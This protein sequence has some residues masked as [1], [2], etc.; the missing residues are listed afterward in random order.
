MTNS[1]TLSAPATTHR[2]LGTLT[3]VVS[4]V[5]GP[6]LIAL[7]L[8]TLHEPWLG[9]LPN[10]DVVDHEHG[11]L[12]LSFNL[13]AAAFPFLFG[14]VFA[15]ARAARRAPRLAGAGLA[16]SVLGLSAMFANAMLSVPIVL[17][18]GIAEHAPLDELAGRL[19]QP[20]LV[21]L[22]L[23]PLFLVGSI[24]QAVALRR[25][26]VLSRWAALAIGV[27]GLFPAAMVLGIGVL[28]LPIAALRIAGSVPIITVT[29]GTRMDS[30]DA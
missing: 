26:G 4:L 29:L 25:A 12:M 1:T 22:Y 30:S 21:F 19:A 6:A 2:P 7:A 3:G 23:F 14:S 18:N 20:P 27:G 17:M 28:A 9:D 16:C 8:A 5:L 15:L 13:V 24:L 10:H 11:L